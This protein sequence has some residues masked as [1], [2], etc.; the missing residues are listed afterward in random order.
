[1]VRINRNDSIEKQMRRHETERPGAYYKNMTV[2]MENAINAN[3]SAAV[4]H[5]SRSMVSE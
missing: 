4:A 3:S 2:K 1:M 5:S